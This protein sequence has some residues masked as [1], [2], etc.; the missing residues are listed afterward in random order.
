MSLTLSF[1][2]IPEDELGVESLKWTSYYG[3]T[4]YEDIY[5]WVPGYIEPLI[6]GYA[7]LVVNPY[8]ENV[9][10]YTIQE[11]FNLYPIMGS[12]G[13]L[14]EYDNIVFTGITY[15]FLIRPNIIHSLYIQPI[16]ITI[17]YNEPYMDENQ[18]TNQFTD[19]YYVIK[20]TAYGT[21][22]TKNYESA[23]D[24]TTLIG[25]TIF[26]SKTGNIILNL[27]WGNGYYTNFSKM[28]KFKLYISVEPNK[29]EI[30]IMILT[31]K[32]QFIIEYITANYENNFMI[33]GQVKSIK[34][35][36]VLLIT[37]NYNSSSELVGKTFTITRKDGSTASI[38]TEESTNDEGNTTI[39]VTNSQNEN[40]K[41]EVTSYK[42]GNVHISDNFGNGYELTLTENMTSQKEI[43]TISNSNDNTLCTID[44]SYGVITSISY[45]DSNGQTTT[46]TSEEILQEITNNI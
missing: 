31:K 24:Y 23:Y 40:D 15:S 16:I 10:N 27:N 2:Q 18:I 34:F 17:S 28:F 21:L 41:L 32:I 12:N 43:V 3:L 7:Y 1:P 8:G 9:F 33:G 13:E 26:L 35:Q 46:E 38:T 5:S 36:N 39:S 30:G 44:L 11:L 4:F 6:I 14:T 20:P 25:S 42:D 19:N 22:F 37:Y 29:K 45:T